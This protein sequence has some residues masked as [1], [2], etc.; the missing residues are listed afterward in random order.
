MLRCTYI[1]FLLFYRKYY[2]FG[3]I[4]I[5]SK[6]SS[7]FSIYG[8]SYRTVNAVQSINRFVSA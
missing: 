6:T 2:V 4:Q 3:I 8:V 5:M 7:Y 1:G